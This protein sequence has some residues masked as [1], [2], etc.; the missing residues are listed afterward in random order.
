MPT[1]GL[2]RVG[3]GE[4]YVDVDRLVLVEAMEVFCSGGMVMVLSHDDGSDVSYR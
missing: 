4:L 3:S 2:R 1:W